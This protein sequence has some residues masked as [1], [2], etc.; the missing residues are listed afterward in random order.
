MTKICAGTQ[1]FDINCAVF[2]K[3]GTLMDFEQAWGQ[4]IR[5]WIAFIVD[6]VGGNEALSEALFHMFG[7]DPKSHEVAV[8][9]PILAASGE[10]MKTL[11]AGVLYQ[12]IGLPWH[13][14]EKVAIESL[15]AAFGSPLTQEEIQ[16]LGDVKGTI[17]S[18][19]K[20]GIAIAV[21][22]ADNRDITEHC[23]EMLGIRQDVD[24][25]MCGDDPLPQKP[26]RGVLGHIASELK[27][28]PGKI[29]M[30]GDTIND[31][32]T[33]RN[34]NV[35]GCIGISPNGTNGAEVLAPYAD[36]V[37]PTVAEIEVECS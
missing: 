17:R 31:L 11:C 28:E 6:K 2:D 35:A 18:M 37:L 36:A 5:D 10:T 23:L 29:L 21:A 9:G 15:W 12:E 25:L 16:P 34:A 30:V 24:L 13:E 8:D 3:D 19:R 27:T 22:T 33:G 26:D 1:Q 7:Y 20:S 14:G 4:R 32:L